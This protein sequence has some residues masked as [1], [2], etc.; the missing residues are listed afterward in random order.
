M[1]EAEFLNFEKDDFVVLESGIEFD[2]LVQREESVRFYTKKEQ[3]QDAFE[4]LMPKGRTTLAQ[5]NAV[6]N[7]VLHYS[8]LY[9]EYI[10][11]TEDDYALKEAEKTKRVDWVMPIYD[12]S[13]ERKFSKSDVS[14]R[15]QALKLDVNRNAANYYS[16]MIRALPRPYGDSQVENVYP[17]EQI[18]E[19]VNSDG[20]NP[21]RALPAY[22][23]VT[24]LVN[25]DKTID[26]RRKPVSETEDRVPFLGYY[27]QERSVDVPNP[28][29]GHPFFE[30]KEANT[31]LTNVSFSDTFPDIEAIFEHGIPVTSDPYGEAKPYL[32]IYDVKLSSVPWNVWKSRFPPAPLENEPREPAALEF[33]P[34]AN[35]E[36]PEKIQ[37]QYEAPHYPGMSPREWLMRQVD[38][39]SLIVKLLQSKASGSGSVEMLPGI[40]IPIPAYQKSTVEE[41]RLT[42]LSFQDFSIR[43]IL[44]RTWEM[45]K[46]DQIDLTCVPMEYVLQ[47][48]SRVGYKGRRLWKDGTEEEI[49]EKHIRLIKKYIRTFDTDKK[50]EL[51]ERTPM[52]EIS[53][54]RKE[55]LVLLKDAGRDRT[56]KY[57]DIKALL[58]DAIFSENTYTDSTGSFVVCAHTMGLLAGELLANP[59]SYYDTWGVQDSGFYVCKVCGQHIDAV[60]FDTSDDFDDNGMIVRRTVAL[61]SV[62][63]DVLIPSTALEKIKSLFDKN[64]T[65]HSVMFLLIGVLQVEP[66][67]AKLPMYLNLASAA[68][69]GIPTSDA[70]KLLRGIIG[71][72]TTAILL[73]THD[74][75]LVPRRAFGSRPLK[76]NGFPRDT[77]STE[78][79]TIFDSLLLA[80]RKTFEAY[81]TAISDMYN[82][83]VRE[84]VK[85]SSK[86]RS[87]AIRVFNERFVKKQPEV[88]TALENAKLRAPAPKETAE[89][90]SE[91]VRVPEKLGTIRECPPCIGSRAVLR[92]SRLPQI[93][94]EMAPLRNGIYAAGSR[95]EIQKSESLRVES[96]P[97]EKREIQR[98]VRMKDALN[99]TYFAGKIGDGIQ[100]NLAI[101]SR[102]ADMYQLPKPIRQ[103][104]PTQ[105]S[106]ELRDYARGL[107]YELVDSIRKI[108]ANVGDFDKRIRADVTLVTLLSNLEKEKKEVRRIS[109]SERLS[110]VKI[111]AKMTDIERD[112]NTQLVKIGMGPVIITLEDRDLL[113]KRD[114]DEYKEIDKEVGVGLPQNN[115]LDDGNAYRNADNGDYGDLAGRAEGRDE[116]VAGFA[117]DAER[118][119]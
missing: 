80:V 60:E 103:V 107:V 52:T 104:D 86:V 19:F 26:I 1:S 15:G 18:T 115:A 30:S 48:Q 90:L 82:V 28:L 69:E 10:V 73:Q 71:L 74:P 79:D 111:N 70:G 23:I 77:S 66:T 38:G 88:V 119:I 102:L 62:R 8:E 47:E 14:D 58:E 12:T 40:E 4:R 108:P 112:I 25:S 34:S 96:A 118:G 64:S 29:P 45:G 21:I 85:D 72:I 54:K 61:D 53:E 41:C 37:D 17:I 13:V 106:E 84:V 87:V 44:R 105:N 63:E 56:D 57:R 6:R 22:E 92:G 94:Q 81:P 11:P 101:A 114:E 36:I 117:D 95:K 7:E 76:L 32:K 2:E 16:R 5:R 35:T 20:K 100:T 109:A 83:F 116:L 33:E 98:L 97:V 55:V 9:D 50:E 93:R 3:E 27:L 91:G 43:G 39:G 49:K 67:A 113:A 68:S 75:I 89:V 31:I 99:G 24:G 65:A 78:G 110:Y 42:N 51:R 46:K 59:K